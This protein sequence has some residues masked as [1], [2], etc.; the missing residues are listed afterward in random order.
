[1]GPITD[2]WSVVVLGVASVA[3]IGL[4]LVSLA[5]AFPEQLSLPSMARVILLSSLLQLLVLALFFAFWVFFTASLID[6]RDSEAVRKDTTNHYIFFLLTA[7]PSFSIAGLL[8]CLALFLALNMFVLPHCPPAR[9]SA[10]LFGLVTGS[11]LALPV[12]F[13][14]SL[15][16]HHPSMFPTLESGSAEITLSVFIAGAVISLLLKCTLCVHVCLTAV[17]NAR[18]QT[19][20]LEYACSGLGEMPTET[21]RKEGGD[22]SAEVRSSRG[23]E[24]MRVQEDEI[25]LVSR[26]PPTT[27]MPKWGADL[28][29]ALSYPFSAFKIT[30]LV[31]V[32][33]DNVIAITVNT[34][35]TFV[36]ED[37]IPATLLIV[38]CV[39]AAVTA[40]GCA[41]YLKRVSAA[42]APCSSSV[43][44]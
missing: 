33:A 43:Q 10:V 36:E 11:G 31:L 8:E 19:Q 6:I 13:E 18:L 25:S 12:S 7:L 4:L 27:A 35:V 15:T 24:M 42:S 3:F 44:A 26:A 34:I 16:A 2:Q 21:T 17:D 29:N 20:R 38:A 30:L 5:W 32:V 9:R 28:V 40:T 39:V 37:N 14:L 1:M 23:V 22:S 41:V